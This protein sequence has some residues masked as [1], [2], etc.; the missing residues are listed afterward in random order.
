MEVV[1][2]GTGQTE[3]LSPEAVP[4]FTRAAFDAAAWQEQQKQWKEAVHIYSRIIQAGVPAKSEA[5]KRIEKI[6][7]E[8]A[9]AF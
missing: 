7:R 8:Y 1:Y 3:P 9:S 6:E 4:W 2:S 5:Q